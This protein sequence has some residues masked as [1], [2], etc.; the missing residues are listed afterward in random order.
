MSLLFMAVQILLDSNCIQGSSLSVLT[1]PPDMTTR[2][3]Q[4]HNV[5][6]AKRNNLDGLTCYLF[7]YQGCMV[8]RAASFKEKVRL[9]ANNFKPQTQKPSAYVH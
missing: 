7:S 9:S 6:L 8:S 1:V 4:R 5:L 3:S 2:G